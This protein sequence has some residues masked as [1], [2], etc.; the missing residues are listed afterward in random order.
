[1]TEQSIARRKAATEV[2]KLAN[3]TMES[4]MHRTV[5][6]DPKGKGWIPCEFGV[7]GMMC[8]PGKVTE[9][10]ELF[11]IAYEVFPDMVALNQV[12]LAYEIIGDK[13]SATEYFGKMKEQAGRENDDVYAQAAEAGLAR[14]Q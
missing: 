9:A 2:F 12:A 7:E 8:R 1:M 5:G 10:I 6:R 14:C 4:G 3:K 11:R 13:K